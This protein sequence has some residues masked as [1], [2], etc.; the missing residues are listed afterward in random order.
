MSEVE[1]D[2]N[3]KRGIS[4][5]MFGKKTSFNSLSSLLQEDTKPRKS[6]TPDTS[7]AM[8]MLLNSN[9]DNGERDVQRKTSRV[10]HDVFED[11]PESGEDFKKVSIDLGTEL[12]VKF[13]EDELPKNRGFIL[14]PGVAKIQIDTPHKPPIK[15]AP[16][17]DNTFTI[18]QPEKKPFIQKQPTKSFTV[19]GPEKIQLDFQAIKLS[20]MN[21]NP[22]SADCKDTA[23]ARVLDEVF[24]IKP[25]APVIQPDESKKE[26]SAPPTE[27]PKTAKI[28]ADRSMFSF[29]AKNSPTM[30][31]Y[32]A[33]DKVSRTT[34]E[35]RASFLSS[36]AMSAE[37][38]R[39]Q[40]VERAEPL[41]S[42]LVGIKIYF[43]DA[44]HPMRLR[45]LQRHC[46]AYDGD[47]ASTLK[48]ATHFITDN[49]KCDITEQEAPHLKVVHS[50][51]LMA[52]HKEQRLLSENAFSVDRS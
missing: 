20:K 22:Q 40:I 18:E 47:V 52:C 30:R 41:A 14:Q 27:S 9:I 49:Y 8:S 51:W 1:K 16:L 10:Q 13:A 4:I 37:K 26:D 7:D 29:D 34:T 24:V 6:Q 31:R 50:E 33:A 3:V 44:I 5:R 28:D 25:R 12:S 46:L 48:K 32:S 36:I 19:R 38:P 45:L 39:L 43:D 35:K 17:E 21:P 23:T 42:F 2:K 11:D 15:P